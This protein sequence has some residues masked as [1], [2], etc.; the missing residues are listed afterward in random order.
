[1]QFMLDICESFAVDYDM[2]FNCDKSVAMRIGSRYN[3]ICADLTLFSSLAA[4]L[5]NKLTRYCVIN[6]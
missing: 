6:R 4:R 2:K 1:M 5:F 3:C